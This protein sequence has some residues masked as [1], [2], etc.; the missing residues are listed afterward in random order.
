MAGIFP[1]GARRVRRDDAGGRPR[2]DRGIHLF[3]RSPPQDALPDGWRPILEERLAHWRHL[4][5]EEQDRLAE[6]TGLLLSRK[7][8][9]AARGFE[10]TAEMSL[11]IA[12]QAALLV[13]GLSYRHY[14]EVGAIIVHPS[15]VVLR[16]PR[17]APVPGLMTDAPTPILGQAAHRGP[18]LLAWDAAAHDARHP[19]RGHN[20]VFHE[21]AHKLDMLDDVVDGTPPLEPAQRARWVDVCTREYRAVQQGGDSL[22]SSYAGVNPGEFFAV[23]TEVFFDRPVDLRAHK[24]ELYGVLAAFY[25]QDPAARV[26]RGT[27]QGGR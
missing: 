12:A 11:L 25:R 23:A 27:T 22:L 1:D 15:T 18:I 20:V 6:L 13:L 26:E 3:R 7:H 5:A 24:P 17:G 14:R 8:W 10:L 4:D 19:E 2:V 16:G 9:E 21:F